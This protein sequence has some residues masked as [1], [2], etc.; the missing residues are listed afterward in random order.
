MGRR[1]IGQYLILISSAAWLSFVAE[2]VAVRPTF[3]LEPLK[4]LQH[5]VPKSQKSALQSTVAAPNTDITPSMQNTNGHDTPAQ[6]SLSA[7]HVSK[8]PH[9]PPIPSTLSKFDLLMKQQQ[10][11]VTSTDTYDAP[12]HKTKSTQD[13]EKVQTPGT[14]VSPQPT[15]S[16]SLLQEDKLG[17]YDKTFVIKLVYADLISMKPILIRRITLSHLLRRSHSRANKGHSDDDIYVSSS[18][19][20][21]ERLI[22]NAMYGL[23]DD[24]IKTVDDVAL[25]YKDVDGDLIMISSTTELLDAIDQ[26][27]LNPN[28]KN[29]LRLNVG[30][31]NRQG[32]TE[33][34][35][36]REDPV[37]VN[38]GESQETKATAS[39]RQYP[40][41]LVDSKIGT[42]TSTTR[43]SSE[44]VPGESNLEDKHVEGST[45]TQAVSSEVGD[46]QQQQHSSS[47][48]SATAVVDSDE[49]AGAKLEEM[50]VLTANDTQAKTSRNIEEMKVECIEDAS[51][52]NESDEEIVATY[53]NGVVIYANGTVGVVEPTIGGN[54]VDTQESSAPEIWR[55]WKFPFGIS[56]SKPNIVDA[57]SQRV[58]FNSILDGV[59]TTLTAA[60]KVLDTVVPMPNPVNTYKKKRAVSFIER[61]KKKK[62]SQQRQQKQQ[63]QEQPQ[64]NLDKKQK[65]NQAERITPTIQVMRD[66]ERQERLDAEQKLKQPP[67]EAAKQR[68]LRQAQPI[69]KKI[70]KHQS[71]PLDQASERKS[72]ALDETKTRPVPPSNTKVKK[73]ESLGVTASKSL[74]ASPTTQKLQGATRATENSLKQQSSV[75]AKQS[76]LQHPKHRRIGS[77]STKMGETAIPLQPQVEE[78]HERP[79]IHARHTCDSCKTK[80]ILGKRYRATSDDY[81]LCEICYN[82][83]Q[84]YFAG[85]RPL[86]FVE[87]QDGTCTCF[88]RENC[89]P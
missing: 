47:L 17:K 30:I 77:T 48:R 68:N 8:L 71:P 28:H 74:Q 66:M 53:S 40:N 85:S 9:P 70:S 36:T 54:H 4:P 56:S 5:T 42:G 86:E 34:E 27:Y 12:I 55:K 72:V 13:E 46:A 63:R 29:C 49:L 2:L 60:E 1:N 69:E 10:I 20:L 51:S 11:G 31:V 37:K 16:T 15:P 87:Q 39:V 78:R 19:S 41:N 75:R 81:D 61:T 43:I 73:S 64:P 50:S 89:L 7:Q 35:A 52:T 62:R 80:P 65:P 14:K 38:A 22:Y 32:T 24:E 67:P 45:V 6:A 83:P 57:V 82:R 25:H 88:T 59:A 26:F 3:A 23:S 44:E 33:A 21:Y 84:K 58:S 18:D 76:P 79:F